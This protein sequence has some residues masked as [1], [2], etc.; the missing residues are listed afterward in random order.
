MDILGVQEV[1]EDRVLEEQPF[2]LPVPGISA[3]PWRMACRVL[4]RGTARPPARML[5]LYP[6][7]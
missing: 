2:L 4:R 5:P 1:G 6:R 7:R 3:I